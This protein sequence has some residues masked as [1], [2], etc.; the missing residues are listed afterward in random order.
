M[1]S[2]STIKIIFMLSFLFDLFITTLIVLMAYAFCRYIGI[3]ENA[4]GFIAGCLFTWIL[5][6][7]QGGTKA[8]HSDDFENDE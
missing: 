5:G 7:L 3:H 1:Y 8:K 4:S 6:T 2:T